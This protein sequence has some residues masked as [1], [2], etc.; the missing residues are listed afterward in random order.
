MMA[1]IISPGSNTNRYNN[2]M[3][4]TNKNHHK[5]QFWKH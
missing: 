3:L 1:Q 5:W 4:N 2:H